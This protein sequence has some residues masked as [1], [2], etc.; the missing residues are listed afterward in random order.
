VNFAGPVASAARMSA[1]RQSSLL[2]M[3]CRPRC[4]WL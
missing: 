2:S 4:R 1:A 3:R